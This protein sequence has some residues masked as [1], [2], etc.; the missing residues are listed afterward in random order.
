MDPI[1]T[2]LLYIPKCSRMCVHMNIHNDQLLNT[3]EN[4]Q[5]TPYSFLIVFSSSKRFQPFFPDKY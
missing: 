5:K 2:E 3:Q 1:S 4:I